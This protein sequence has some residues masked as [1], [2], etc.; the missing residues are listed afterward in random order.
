MGEDQTAELYGLKN[1]KELNKLN[2]YL[3]S[4]DYLRKTMFDRIFSSGND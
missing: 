1:K 3:K 4:D 2:E